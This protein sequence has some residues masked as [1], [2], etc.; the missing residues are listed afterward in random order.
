MFKLALLKALIVV[1][2]QIALLLAAVRQ[3]DSA[4]R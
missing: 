4:V 2:G 1:G 3:L